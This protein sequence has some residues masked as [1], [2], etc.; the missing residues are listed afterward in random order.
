MMLLSSIVGLPTLFGSHQ[1]FEQS[2]RVFLGMPL[3][4]A[5]P[6]IDMLLTLTSFIALSIASPFNIFWHFLRLYSIKF[7]KER[8]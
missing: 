2:A 6:L 3:T 7:S 1:P 4:L 8:K 5:D